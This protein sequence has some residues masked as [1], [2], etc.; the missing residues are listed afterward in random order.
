MSHRQSSITSVPN[1]IATDADRRQGTEFLAHGVPP[2]GSEAQESAHRVLIYVTPGMPGRIVR[3]W[4][5]ESTVRLARPIPEEELPGDTHAPLERDSSSKACQCHSKGGALPGAEHV[6]HRRYNPKRCRT[7]GRD[8]NAASAERSVAGGVSAIRED[9]DRR[10]RNAPLASAH[11][12][13]LATSNASAAAEGRR[14]YSAPAR[15]KTTPRP[16]MRSRPN[17]TI[18][19][20]NVA[21]LD[22]IIDDIPRAQGMP[23]PQACRRSRFQTKIKSASA[24]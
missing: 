3:T 9:S 22:L 2:D 5:W 13:I 7:Y 4:T 11:R 8:L 18:T 10:A 12:R 6:P 17:M 21:R 19:W 23:P 1:D 15:K 16:R 20:T 14:T 24:T